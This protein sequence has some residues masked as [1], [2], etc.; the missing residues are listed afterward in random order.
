MT[1]SVN[2]RREIARRQFAGAA[3]GVIGD[4]GDDVGKTTGR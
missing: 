3:D 2:D 4:A 1:S